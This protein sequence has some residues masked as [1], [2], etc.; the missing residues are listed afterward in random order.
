M[1][2]KMLVV[3]MVLASITLIVAGCTGSLTGSVKEEGTPAAGEPAKEAFSWACS[4]QYRPFNFYDEKNN[5][6]G[7]DVEIGR[8]LCEK[9]GMEPKPVTAPWDSLINGLQAKRYDAILGSMTITEERKQQVDFSD[10]YYVSGA[11]LFVRKE[12]TGIKSA[13]DLKQDTKIGVLTN[14]TYDKEARKYSKN[15]VNYQSDETALRDLNAGRVD[16]VITDRF[17]GKLAIDETGLKNIE[18]VGDLL[19]VEEVGIAFR[20]GDDAL[21]EKVN[22]ALKAIKDDGTYLKISNKYFGQ[23]ISK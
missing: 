5:L 14:S 15:I 16:A 19:F 4:G 1:A 10:P 22:A 12:E 9:M 17:V 8:A 18:M 11:Q 23:D 3:L 6:T 20:K 13:A 7:F 2:R 21:R